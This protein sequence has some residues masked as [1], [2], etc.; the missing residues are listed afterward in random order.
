MNH[1]HGT[2]ARY[3]R[4]CRCDHCRDANRRWS[5]AYK[6]RTKADPHDGIPRFPI[7]TDTAPI[8]DH[9]DALIASGWTLPA[10]SIDTGL[11]Y[12]TVRN[13]AQRRYPKCRKDHAATLLD[14]APLPDLGDYIDPVVVERLLNGIPT[15]STRSERL[16]AVRAA[17][18]RD[19]W[20]ELAKRLGI[21]STRVKAIAEEIRGGAA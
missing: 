10:L 13:I 16:A 19:G 11:A 9:I 5:K 4:G 20:H 8:A 14:V 15:V 3:L 2:R 18:G 7:R 6:H 17:Y 1:E 21:N 12:T